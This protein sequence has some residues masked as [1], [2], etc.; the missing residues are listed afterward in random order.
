VYKRLDIAVK[1]PERKGKKPYGKWR[2]DIPSLES[3]AEPLSQLFFGGMVDP[4][5][6]RYDWVQN[7]ADIAFGWTLILSKR[8]GGNEQCKG[9]IT[10]VSIMRWDGLRVPRKRR[11][12]YMIQTTLHEQIH[13]LETF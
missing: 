6:V 3:I 7:Y 2:L 1:T 10:V 12:C 5:F 13:A 4:S 9:C 11:T 8:S